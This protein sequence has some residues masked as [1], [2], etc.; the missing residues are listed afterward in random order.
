MKTLSDEI[1]NT[2]NTEFFA[3][4]SDMTEYIER[5]KRDVQSPIADGLRDNFP[6]LFNKLL[7]QK[8]VRTRA[9]ARLQRWLHRHVTARMSRIQYTTQV[10]HTK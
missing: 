9:I 6:T 4:A 10:I 3:W 7:R 5:A 8:R 1:Y 2:T